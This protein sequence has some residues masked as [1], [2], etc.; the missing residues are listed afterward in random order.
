MYFELGEFEKAASLIKRGPHVKMADAD[1]YYAAVY[2]YLGQHEK[3]RLYWN[4]FLEI[5]RKLFKKENDFDVQEAIDWI[6]KIGP[7]RYK[8]KMEAF[9][10]HIG[11]GSFPATINDASTPAAEG[12]KE[13]HFIKEATFWKLSYD[14]SVM[15]VPELKGFFDIQQMLLEPRRVFHCAELM[16]SAVNAKGEKLLDEKARKQYQKKIIDL[17]AEIREAEEQS[18][19]AAQVKLQADYDKLIDHLSKALG[20]KG[21]ARETGGTVEKARSA[22]TWRIRKAIARIE[23]CHPH[24]GAHLSNAI[25]TGTVCSYQP[26]RDIQ[27]LTS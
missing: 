3:M 19:S 24:L 23:Q 20:L 21:K 22:V 7:Y 9:L 10:R 12:R 8:T 1:A 11:D 2:Y 17:Q 15:Q 13:N 16:G 6:V 5:Y 27:W 14:G 25:K 4:Y 18:D 26:D